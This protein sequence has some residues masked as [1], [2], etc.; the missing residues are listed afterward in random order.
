MKH[1]R[2]RLTYANALST[3]CL[4]L[5]LGG[6]AFAAFKL[7]KNT[8]GPKQLRKNAVTGT[9]VKNQS[10]TGSDIVASSLGTVP[11][12]TNASHADAAGDSATLQGNEPN[13]FVHGDGSVF[14][15]RRDMDVGADSIPLLDLPGV[16]TLTAQC[17]AGPTEAGF[18]LENTSGAILDAWRSFNSAA[19]EELAFAA[20][21]TMGTNAASPTLMD[22]EAATR[23]PTP[24]IA[25]LR[26]Y[27]TINPPQGKA[28]LVFA[29]ATV[30]Q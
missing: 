19:P 13:A 12:A 27:L 7:P 16:A 30:S 1:V 2:R 15:A 23:G 14:V 9:K 24:K 3:L 4:F 28:C 11:R 5:L 8:V 29:H 21:G 6:G 20:G 18:R 26:V 17:K 10:L 25:A 22:L